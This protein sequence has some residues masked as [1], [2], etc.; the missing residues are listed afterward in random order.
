MPRRN[1]EKEEQAAEKRR[2]KIP[3]ERQLYPLRRTVFVKTPPA[4]STGKNKIYLLI[5]RNEVLFAVLAIAV[6][7]PA[8]LTFLLLCKISIWHSG[9]QKQ[10]CRKHN[11]INWALNLD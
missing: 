11:T 4:A 1:T 3:L 5:A 9:F 8:L 2:R 6:G 10:I 7:F